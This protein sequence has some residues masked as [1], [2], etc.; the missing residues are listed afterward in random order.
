MVGKYVDLTDA[1]K[2]LNEA[3]HHGGVA[4]E[5]KVEIVYVDSEKL[6]DAAELAHVDGILVPHGFG[7]RGVEGKIRAVRYARER[8]V[9]YFGICYGM[10]MAVIEFAR[11]VAGLERASSAEVDPASPHPV[12]A[13][14]PEQREVEAK[15]ATM[16]LGAWP[17]I[18]RDGTRA[19]EAYQAREISERHR[20]RYEFNPD[21]RDALSRAGLVLSGTSPDGRLVEV[22]ELA[23]HPWFVGC[24]FH[25]EFKST[26]FRPHPLFVAFIRAA[27]ER[28]GAARH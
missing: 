14:L 28:G 18:L 5:A 1:Y 17:C 12:I 23:D 7:S 15:G 6:D 26:P 21:Y 25:P 3:L 2:S 22:V 10:Q 11:H 24:Q 8:R 13:L 27:V 16:R 4:N 9:P 20:H 19:F